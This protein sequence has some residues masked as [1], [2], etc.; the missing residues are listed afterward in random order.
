M[1]G[2]RQRH[3]NFISLPMKC[4][5]QTLQN[6]S[7]FEKAHLTDQYVASEALRTRS[8]S[9]DNYVPGPYIID[10]AP[11][12]FLRALKLIPTEYVHFLH[13]S[14]VLPGINT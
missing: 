3:I 8:G 14:T 11:P 9:G 10:P 6:F 1:Y 12:Y 13:S 5:S 4:T 7:S 2:L